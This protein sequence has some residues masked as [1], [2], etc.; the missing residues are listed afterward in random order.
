MR[1]KFS[2]GFRELVLTAGLP[3]VLILVA[4]W[5]AA[6]Y[7]APAPPRTI[8]VATA[9]KGSPYY[10]VAQRYRSVLAGNG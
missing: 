10:E 5:F 6:Q 7:V 1:G 8:T 4:F 9:T 3:L 2:S